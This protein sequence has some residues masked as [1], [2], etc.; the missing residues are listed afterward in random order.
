VL[1]E[2]LLNDRDA[3][4][5]GSKS[6]D[7]TSSEGSKEADNEGKES[8]D[9][10][11][12]KSETVQSSVL[13]PSKKTQEK[14][15]AADLEPSTASKDRP[16]QNQLDQ[17]VQG[18]QARLEEME[19]G[20]RTMQNML[21]IQMMNNQMSQNISQFNRMRS[22]MASITTASHLHNHGLITPTA[23]ADFGEIGTMAALTSA[24]KETSS[25]H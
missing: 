4:K 19:Q 11:G 21:K 14:R 22:E 5:G 9:N 2:L 13:M 18:Y 25:Q 15:Q 3:L 7:S 24:Q 20:M 12:E 6:L 23:P 8:D 16:E 17:I 1:L 10:G